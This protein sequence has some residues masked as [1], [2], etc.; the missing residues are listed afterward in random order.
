MHAHSASTAP[1]RTADPRPLDARRP[2]SWRE[3][4]GL[5]RTP[6]RT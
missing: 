3:L 2:G 4:P 6:P 5:S 1:P